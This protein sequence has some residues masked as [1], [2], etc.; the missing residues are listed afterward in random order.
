M[1]TYIKILPVL[2][3]T[4]L[5]LLLACGDQPADEKQEYGET[6]RITAE[7]QN[8]MQQ[9]LQILDLDGSDLVFPRYQEDGY[10][11]AARLPLIDHVLSSPFY[12][13]Y[14]A[15]VTSSQLQAA[16]SEGLFDVLA[17]M[18]AT[19]NG[20][21]SYHEPQDTI[22]SDIERLAG[23]YQYLCGRYNAAADIQVLA[24][25]SNAGF[26]VSFDRQLAHLLLVLTEASILVQDAFAGLTS[27]EYDYLSQRPE[28]YFFPEGAMFNFL[29]APTHVARKILTIAR[30]ID[31]VK[32]Y[33]AS[34]V[35][36]DGIDKFT[37]YIKTSHWSAYFQD[38]QKRAGVIV[39]IPSPLGNIVIT[40]QDDGQHSGS[41]AL[42]LDLGGNDHYSGPVAAGN[43]VPG[44]V[45]VSID[46]GGDDTYDGGNSRYTQGFGCLSIGVLVDLA[47]DDRYL[48]G[49][50]A[51]GSGLFGVGVL[52]D[53]HGK[54][55]YRMGMLGQGFGLF[56]LGVLLDT[57]SEDKYT[58]NGLGQG[59]GSTMG[60]GVLCDTSGNDKYLAD[61]DKKRGWLLPDDLSHVQGAGLSIR[62]PAWHRNISFYGGIGFLTD[63]DGNDFYYASHGNAMGSSYFMSVGA[64]VDGSG[65]DKYWPDNGWGIASA[66]H[67]TGAV[68]IDRG[69]NDTYYGKTHTGG[70]AS[71]RSIA[72]LADY[73][74][75]D[76]Y[77][78]DEAFVQHLL[79]QREPRQFEL[80]SETEKKQKIRENM[81]RA[82]YAV[83]MKPKS[84]GLLI[85]YRGDDRYFASPVER[86]E[87]CG[88]IIP[89]AEP[90]NWSH[91]I[92]LDLGGD[93]F[94]S[95]P[96][97]K[98]NHYYKYLN[99]GLCYDTDYS[100][101]QLIGKAPLLIGANR[102][103]LVKSV[104][105]ITKKS[106]SSVELSALFDPDLFVRF[107][108]IGKMLQSGSAIVPE[109]FKILNTST[110]SELNRDVIEILDTLILSGKLKPS[111]FKQL[112][113]LLESE[114]SFV[115]VFAARTLADRPVKDALPALIRVSGHENKTVRA[116]VIR[117]MGR[118]GSPTFIETLTAA[119]LNDSSREC[120]YAAVTALARFISGANGADP[121][122]Y[123]TILETLTKGLE[124]PD[125]SVRTFAAQSLHYYGNT[126]TVRQVLSKMLDDNS[127]YVQRA[128]AKS[129]ILNSDKAAIP[130]LINTLT[131]PSI[132]TFAY[133]D[134]DIVKDIAFYCGIDFPDEERYAYATWNK[135][136]Q[137]N[138]A[139]VNL[140][141]NLKIMQAIQS[142][143]SA[144][145]E[146]EG[147]AVFERLM[148][149][150]PGNVVIRKRYILFCNEWINMRLLTR[151]NVSQE[152]FTR[153]LR[154]QQKLTQLEPESAERW[155]RL[156]YFNYRLSKFESAA[157]AMQKAHLIAPENASY[158]EMLN[159]YRTLKQKNRN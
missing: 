136:W 40:G 146:A 28:R 27:E 6:N 126:P 55:D 67:L 33:T 121:T 1:N 158:R 26:S 98:N 32:L 8:P 139:G 138:G 99:H 109:L 43:Q 87:S 104:P 18:T 48:A 77:G 39:N 90:Q 123:P 3:L 42:I 51:Q 23:A 45:A 76:T 5:V 84:L 20:G 116:Q 122:S 94:Y 100:G 153:C 74:G 80:L 71:D 17:L 15:D 150:H 119:V 135:W 49:N 125:D 41:G 4:S 113:A 16:A 85:D 24:K 86:K 61:R 34:L 144:S 130:R 7:E 133:Y 79:K 60:F 91:A 128:A 35:L 25:I 151:A 82:S 50:M 58:I 30:K 110:D 88:G 29:T 132:D 72:L 37:H 21:T 93:D 13:H 31:Y 46:A 47:G 96:G 145:G 38:G 108:A 107:A 149:E 97:R 102:R 140:E 114:D 95:K 143:F 127:V 129:L 14:W 64:L 148:A 11:L 105:A 156:A 56:G 106:T 2:L 12:L 159:H 44:M 52:A 65:D 152:I 112:A 118:I 78:P 59:A 53:Y 62:S 157:A 83:A 92:L 124:D 69:G 111:H 70:A 75:N 54:D 137:K 22:N 154:L 142:A 155:V 131:F 19:L 36:I 81:A 117:A 147:L 66:V 73:A 89:P 10:H 115:Q 101:K 63:G 134:H 141:Q 103:A 57:G 68:L 9:A 120:R